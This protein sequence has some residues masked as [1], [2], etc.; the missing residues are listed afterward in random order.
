MNSVCLVGRVS[1][2]PQTRFEGESQT[3]S[4]TLVVEERSYGSENKQFTLFVPCT[5]WGKSAEVCGLLNQGDLISVQGRLTWRKQVGK[6]GTEHSQLVVSVR[7]V[8]V[9]E[10][11]AV[12]VPA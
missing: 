6:C 7:E 5:S 11:S 3:A 1:R 8:T 9:L 10:A 12:A 2:H 4:F